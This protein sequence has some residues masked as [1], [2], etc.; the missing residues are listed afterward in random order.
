MAG[1][2]GFEAGRKYEV[3]TAVGELVLLP[4][5]RQAATDTLIIADGFSCREQSSDDHAPVLHRGPGPEDGLTKKPLAA[6]SRPSLTRKT[7][8]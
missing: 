3:S 5:V 4:A 8:M 1:N 7:A 6:Q 2:F